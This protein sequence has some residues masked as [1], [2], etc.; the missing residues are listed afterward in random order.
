MILIPFLFF[1][2]LAGLLLSRR[3]SKVYYL[4]L[5]AL[6]LTPLLPGEL[7]L[8]EVEIYL[9][10]S[11][12]FATIWSCLIHKQSVRQLLWGDKLSKLMIIWFADMVLSYALSGHY[13]GWGLR[14]LLR[15]TSYIAYYYVFRYW[16]CTDKRVN[17]TFLI[18]SIVVLVSGALAVLQVLSGGFPQ[19]F[20]LVYPEFDQPCLGRAYGF[21]TGG[22]NAFGG[23]MDLLL[24]IDIALFATCRK[25][26]LKSL[27]GG[28]FLVGAVGQVLSGSRS[29][30]GALIASLLM[31][32]YCFSSKAKTRALGIIGAFIVIPT[33]LIVGSIFVPRLLQVSDQESIAPRE[34]I[35]GQSIITFAEHPVFGIGVGNLRETASSDAFQ[36]EAENLDTSN[37]Y[38]Q[39]LVDTGVVGFIVF[40]TLIGYVMWK[41]WKN[42][43]RYQRGSMPHVISY[44]IFAALFSVL[45]QGVVDVLFIVSAAF[46]ATFG[47]ILALSAYTS[48]LEAQSAAAKVVA[49]RE[50]SKRSVPAFGIARS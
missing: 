3:I 19:I 32:I 29:G 16:L 6:P 5:A 34:L 42:L 9:S 22:A 10:F 30:T 26:E 33:L 28:I 48:R 36:M 49:K 11:M 2:L 47:V 25:L 38:L 12:F 20:A 8:R 23:F 14:G 27:Y 45:L 21:V 46:G 31:A 15:L 1:I 50:I 7:P 44:V 40:F 17:K 13:S 39:E 35:W 4:L 43:K 37:L 41:S 18:L 24:P